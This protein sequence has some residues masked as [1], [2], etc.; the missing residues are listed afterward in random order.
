MKLG[1]TPN[2]MSTNPTASLIICFNQI[3]IKL[4]AGIGIM[5]EIHM[6]AKKLLSIETIQIS[7]LISVYSQSGIL[8]QERRKKISRETEVKIM[9]IKAWES[10]VL[11]IWILLLSH[12]WKLPIIYSC[13]LDLKV[14][15]I[16]CPTPNIMSFWRIPKDPK[17]E[18]WL[19][20][21]FT[22]SEMNYICLVETQV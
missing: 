6:Y 13:L 5:P 10:V 7:E 11:V 16:S 22:L 2:K 17:L 3:T 21:V 19:G 4:Q 1:S 12:K 8:V 14:F 20:Q 18:I 9:K 15:V